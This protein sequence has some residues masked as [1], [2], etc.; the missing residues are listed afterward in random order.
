[1]EELKVHIQYV[2]L[3]EFKINKNPTETAKKISC[4]YGQSII[5]D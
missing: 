1:M 3:W 5:S 4:V 2:I